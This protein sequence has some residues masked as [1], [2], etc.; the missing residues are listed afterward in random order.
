MVNLSVCI[1]SACHIKG[2]YNMISMFQQMIEE[3]QL[4]DK[5]ELK[6]V[7]CMGNCGRPPERWGA[8]ADYC[9]AG[10]DLFQG[11]GTA[12]SPVSPGFRGIR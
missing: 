8:G 6:G 5:V 10:Q 2:S 3:N 11:K 12:L 4:H 9:A 1:G 7:F